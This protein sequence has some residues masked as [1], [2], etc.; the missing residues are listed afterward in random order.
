MAWGPQAV[1][2]SVNSCH[3]Y[4]LQIT[5]QKP[6]PA[7]LTPLGPSDNNAHIISVLGTVGKTHGYGTCTLQAVW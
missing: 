5:G 1:E 3:M 7:A 4:E 2:L 6:V